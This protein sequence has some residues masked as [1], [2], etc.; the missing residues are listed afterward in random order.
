ANCAENKLLKENKH[1]TLKRCLW[2]KGTCSSC[3]MFMI[4][5]P[6]LNKGTYISPE[7]KFY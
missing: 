3:Q 7:I 4:P 2:K 6:L 1:L 5:P